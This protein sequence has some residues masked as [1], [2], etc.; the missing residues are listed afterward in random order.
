MKSGLDVIAQFSSIVPIVLLMGGLFAGLHFALRKLRDRGRFS[1]FVE[2]RLRLPGHSLRLKHTD[3]FNKMMEGVMLV[4]FG[5]LILAV[6]FNVYFGITKVVWII[7]AIGSA[8]WGARS[9]F[10]NFEKCQSIG[11]GLEGEEYTGEELNLLMRKGAFVF[12]DIPYT[13]GNIDHVI[14]AKD[15]VLVVETKA[16][17]K[18]Q[19]DK[20]GASRMGEVKFNGKSLEFPHCNTSQPIKQARL[21][22]KHVEKIIRET[23][24]IDFPVIPVVALPGWF[25]DTPDDL[26][27]CD[28]L[29]VINPKRGKALQKWMGDLKDK[30]ARDQ[31]ARYI[32]KVARSVPA[33]SKRTDADA[34]EKF[35]FWLNPK[36]S[37][38]ALD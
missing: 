12:H 37:G 34:A 29:L 9:V 18:P 4:A 17:R 19:S 1:P 11:L 36:A 26:P 24:N 10:Q 5:C 2:D 16:V 21:H 13:Y 22:A 7:V 31:V 27:K 38:P 25:V 23:L 30:S 6:A 15:K 28:P 8:L 3:V 14:V 33:H 35:D 20:G 32:A